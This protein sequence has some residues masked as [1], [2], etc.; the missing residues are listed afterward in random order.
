MRNDH[1]SKQIS[2]VILLNLLLAG[3]SFS[4]D[5]LFA[6][7]FGTSQVAD[8]ITLA[9]FIPDTIGNNL[10]AA[11]IGVASVPV[12]SKLFV[13]SL[14]LEFTYTLKQL[15]KT[16][17]VVSLVL[18]LCMLVLGRPILE[19]MAGGFPQEMVTLTLRYYMIMLPIVILF[20]AYMIGTSV[21]YASNRFVVSSLG[22]IFLNLFLFIGILLV[23]MISATPQMGGYIFSFAF[24]A[25]TAFITI[26]IWIMI[27]RHFHHRTARTGEIAKQALGNTYSREIYRVF[28]LYVVIVCGWQAIYFTE[29][30]VA[31]QLG[32]GVIAGQTYA[33]RVSQFTVWVF[34]A[35]IN[36]VVLPQFTKLMELGEKQELRQNVKKYMTWTILGTVVTAILLYVFRVP[37]IEMVFQYGAFNDRSLRITTDIL[38][39]YALAIVGQSLTLICLRYYLA[40]GN[41]KF[42]LIVLVSSS[43]IT[44]ILNIIL[45]DIMG[46][47]GIGYAS[48][49]G[50]SI[51]G[52]VLLFLVF[53]DLQEKLEGDRS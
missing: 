46:P 40:A 22:P 49:V 50:F 28:L 48:L 15:M 33:F 5:V 26:Y 44:I 10:L 6:I 29:R 32:I 53:R 19:V 18:T 47:R 35:A 11:S 52:I 42:P 16:F 17:I 3:V 31:S 14:D 37:F 7:F 1:F 25:G 41:L 20:P 43:L 4:K 12:L 13:R 8:A 51:S 21:L 36:T 45:A 38:E 24:L 30:Y 23:M 2:F 9:F 27:Q 39:G 34:V